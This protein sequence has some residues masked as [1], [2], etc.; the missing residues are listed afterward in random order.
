MKPKPQPSRVEL[1]HQEH[2]RIQKM[3]ATPE[4]QQEMRG[5]Q[6]WEMKHKGDVKKTK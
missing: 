6:S 4:K 5:A 2:A 1:L 3:M